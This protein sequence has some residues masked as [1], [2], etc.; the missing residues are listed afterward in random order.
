VDW[1]AFTLLVALSSVILLL[2][3][4]LLGYAIGLRGSL[5]LLCSAPLT[6]ALISVVAVGL[7]FLPLAWTPTNFALGA[8][9]VVLIMFLGWWLRR[10]SSAHSPHLRIINL[11]PI[12]LLIGLGAATAAVIAMMVALFSSPDY[13][14]QTDANIF[15]LNAVRYSLDSG[16]ASTFAIGQLNAGGCDHSD[17]S[18]C[19]ERLRDPGDSHRA[20]SEPG[21]VH[22]RSSQRRYRL[23]ADP[24]LVARLPGARPSGGWTVDH[25]ESAGRGRQQFDL[26]VPLATIR[27]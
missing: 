5:A 13:F 27:S 19:L 3:G 21:G 14:V 12:S 15:H 6:I 17:L 26:P 22:R 16:Q 4:W 25:P 7:S 20:I 1:P 24:V 23:S 10:L 11:N 18:G 2:P 8:A 9:A